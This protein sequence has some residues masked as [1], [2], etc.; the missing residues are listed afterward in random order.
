MHLHECDRGEKGCTYIEPLGCI[1]P[2][3]TSS[4][5]AHIGIAG[6]TGQL[7][8][9]LLRRWQLLVLQAL[10]RSAAGLVLVLVLVLVLDWIGMG[11]R[12]VLAVAVAVVRG[13]GPSGHDCRIELEME[14]SAVQLSVTSR[15]VLDLVDHESVSNVKKT[16]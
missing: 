3:S 13:H 6:G 11:L 12:L 16:R 14:D 8:Q 9:R 7:H 15:T 4:P 2:F 10:G 5:L 1:S